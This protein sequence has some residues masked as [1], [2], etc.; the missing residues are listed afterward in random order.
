MYGFSVSRKYISVSELF[1]RSLNIYQNHISQF[2]KVIIPIFLLSAILDILF[3]SGIYTIYPNSSW[4]VSTSDGI[5][6]HTDI[7]QY[8]YIRISTLNYIFIWFAMSMLVILSY[9]LIRGNKTS[10]QEVLHQTFNKKWTIF[11]TGLLCLI[12]VVSILIFSVISVGLVGFIFPSAT[13]LLIVGI[14]FIF[15]FAVR[16]SL[17]HQGIMIENLNAVNAMRRSSV[18]VNRKW[19]RFF[20][21]LLLLAWISSLIVNLTLAFTFIILSNASGDLEPIRE[22]ILS[23]ELLTLFYGIPITLNISDINISIGR[24]SMDFAEVPSF[25]IITLV[26]LVK[27]SV[28]ALLTPLW[29]ILTTHLYLEQ[30]EGEVMNGE[31]PTNAFERHV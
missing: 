22:S 21:R 5:T 9:N 3:F 12:G 26:V 18:L 24:I 29:A 23:S 6:V 20:G 10:F 2:W 1:R 27:T 13:M 14:L 16:L 30:M 11:G 4:T 28:V 8:S 15:Y 17:I 7:S 25:W 19:F 31:T